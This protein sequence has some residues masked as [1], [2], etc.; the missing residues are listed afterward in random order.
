MS[1][2]YSPPVV[3]SA[4]TGTGIVLS[5]LTAPLSAF[6]SLPPEPPPQA[7][8]PTGSR[9][10]TAATAKVAD[11]KYFFAP[12]DDVRQSENATWQRFSRL[13]ANSGLTKDCCAQDI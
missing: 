12:A 11:R 4:F 10:T 7:A 8:F 1:K 9:T 6:P 5:S 13:L 2:E 3:L